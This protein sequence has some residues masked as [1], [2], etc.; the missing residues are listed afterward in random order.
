M[1]KRNHFNCFSI[2]KSILG[3]YLKHLIFE[4]KSN[5]HNRTTP[6]LL[7]DTDSTLIGKQTDYLKHDSG[8]TL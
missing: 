4:E 2:S 6:S 8:D 5:F 3:A 7:K 1:Y